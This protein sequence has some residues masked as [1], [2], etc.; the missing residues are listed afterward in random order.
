MEKCL[1]KLKRTL[2]IVLTFVMIVSIITVSSSTTVEAAAKKVVKRLSGVS[3]SKTLNVGDSTTIKAKVTATKKVAKGDLLVTVKSS[4]PSI[5]TVKIIKKPTKKA[6]TGTTQIVVKGVKAGKTTISVTTKSKNKKNKK[7]TKKMTVKVKEAAKTYK[8]GDTVPGSLVE[9]IADRSVEYNKSNEVHRVFFSLKL[10]DDKTRVS[11]SGKIEININ[12]DKNQKV[13]SKTI[14]F[15]PVDFGNW[16]NAYYGTRYLCCIEIPD[17]A[18][19][20]G[21]SSS[22]ILDFTV[23]VNGVSG[24]SWTGGKYT[25][26]YL[27]EGYDPDVNPKPDPQETYDAN[28]DDIVAKVKRKGEFSTYG[29]YCTYGYVSVSA[30]GDT[31]EIF[32]NHDRK[33]HKVTIKKGSSKA[34]ATVNLTVGEATAEFDISTFKGDTSDTLEWSNNP[35]QENQWAYDSAIANVLKNVANYDFYMGS[36]SLQDIGF[37]SYVY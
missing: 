35:S 16:T 37:V 14:P 4:N 27:P 23:Y 12:N 31:I 26:S 22:G 29:G 5:A 33:G 1:V 15:S 24:L 11:T 36:H 13:Y 32:Q 2:A 19:N 9:Y 10:K 21:A 3:S 34:I 20:K 8:D 30:S 7:G 25:I 17:S 18:I 28:F 6:K